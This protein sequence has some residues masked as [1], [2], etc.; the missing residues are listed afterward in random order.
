VEGPLFSWIKIGLDSYGDPDSLTI[1][2]FAVKV[3]RNARSL[4]ALQRLLPVVSPTS[5]CGGVR[6]K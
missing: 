6:I 3:H 1:I 5:C 4:G 2:H